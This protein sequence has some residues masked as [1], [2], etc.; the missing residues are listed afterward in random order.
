MFLRSV[1]SGYSS[2]DSSAAWS[3]LDRGREILLDTGDVECSK[4]VL[5]STMVVRG[6]IG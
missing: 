1:A 4:T 3:V 6:R 2:G 5:T